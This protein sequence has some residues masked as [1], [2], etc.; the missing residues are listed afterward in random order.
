MGGR[1]RGVAE[2]FAGQGRRLR[3]PADDSLHGG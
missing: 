3:P 1:L 2:A